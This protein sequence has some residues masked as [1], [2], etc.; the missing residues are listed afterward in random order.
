MK[1][2]KR[3]I[4]PQD[5]LSPMNPKL[6]GVLPWP[7]QCYEKLD[8]LWLVTPFSRLARSQ[9]K[10][11][12][13]DFSKNFYVLVCTHDCLLDKHS[14]FYVVLSGDEPVVHNQHQQITIVSAEEEQCVPW[15]QI[16]LHINQWGNLG[17][18]KGKKRKT[19]VSVLEFLNQSVWRCCEPAVFLACFLGVSNSIWGLITIWILS[20]V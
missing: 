12:Q 1:W 6:H 4:T 19:L 16:C 7:L 3:K 17:G 11:F 13:R 18:K 8:R 20:L 10:L 2:I 14:L 5:L 15:L 9:P